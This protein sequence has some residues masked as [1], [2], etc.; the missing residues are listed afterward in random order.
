MKKII[1]GGLLVAGLGYGIY[2]FIQKKGDDFK[3]MSFFLSKVYKPKFT[4]GKINLPFQMTISN[5]TKTTF[6]S[7]DIDLK[8]L[9]KISTYNSGGSLTLIATGQ[10]TQADFVV[11]PNNESKID[12]TLVAPM[13][14]LGIN[15][16][17][18]FSI[19]GIQVDVYPSA[20]DYEFPVMTQKINLSLQELNLV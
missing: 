5:P 18:L 16:L 9:V 8:L 1:F 13:A 15:L 11:N 7:K 10:P 20:L 12:L 19:K 4:K 3:K 6:K 17:N 14:N 2:R